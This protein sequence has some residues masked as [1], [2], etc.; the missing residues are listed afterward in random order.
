MK[1][2]LNFALFSFKSK[3]GIHLEI[4]IEICVSCIDLPTHNSFPC[5]EALLMYS[6]SQNQVL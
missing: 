4:N 2:Q 1:Q 6:G 5:N 3:T